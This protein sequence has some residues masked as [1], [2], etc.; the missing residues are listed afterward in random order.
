MEALANLAVIAIQNAENKKQLV[1]VERITTLGDLAGPLMH[2]MKNHFG[3]IKVWA[4]DILDEG[5]E[6]SKNTATKI[7]QHTEK[8]LEE[9]KDLGN[10]TDV[11]PEL[12]ELQEILSEAFSQNNFP[13]NITIQYITPDT[14]PKVLAGKYQLV[15]VF[16]NLIQNAIEA[17]L[18]G[19]NLSVEIRSIKQDERAWV[20]VSVKDTGV[21]IALEYSEQIFN[22]EYTTKPGH[23]GFGLWWAKAYIE[24]LGG[25]LTVETPHAS[26]SGS[27]VSSARDDK[28]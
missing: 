14:L 21:G 6:Y 24:R 11:K 15:G 10:W 8:A 17:T 20:M 26:I 27:L 23:P 1:A 4:K 16:S 9:A 25:Y 2:R 18:E 28:T 7:L 12:I 3:A 19:G 5:N 13:S 22:A